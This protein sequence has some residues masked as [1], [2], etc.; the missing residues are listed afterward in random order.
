MGDIR[1][2]ATGRSDEAA[3]SPEVRKSRIESFHDLDHGTGWS[4]RISN[5]KHAAITLGREMHEDSPSQLF[6]VC[7]SRFGVTVDTDGWRCDEVGMGIDKTW[8]NK[9]PVPHRRHTAA[10]MAKLDPSID[11]KEI[12]A[13][14]FSE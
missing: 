13:R 3:R 5:C 10:R 4:S 6:G 11:H 8:E 2:V 9:P 14:L 12:F 7:V 1:H